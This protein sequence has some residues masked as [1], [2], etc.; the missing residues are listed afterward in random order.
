MKLGYYIPQIR[1]NQVVRSG[2]VIGNLLLTHHAYGYRVSL[3]YYDRPG[4]TIDRLFPEQWQAE[5]YFDK[6]YQE[7]KA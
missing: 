4:Y 6:V 7:A 1:C 2:K 5:K 3:H